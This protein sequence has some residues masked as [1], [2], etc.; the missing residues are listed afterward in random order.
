LWVAAWISGLLCTTDALTR[1][2]RDGTLGLLFLTDLQNYDIVLGKLA[3]T[4]LQQVMLLVGVLPI[5][6][7]ALA[8]GGVTA[9]EFW[10]TVASLLLCQGTSLALGLACSA[11]AKTFGGSLRATAFCLAVPILIPLGIFVILVNTTRTIPPEIFSLSPLLH[12][13]AGLD[14]FRNSF[15]AA[16]GSWE[17]G[18][19]VLLGVI[20]ASFGFACT[21]IRR[22]QDNPERYSGRA[23]ST[24]GQSSSLT[25][26]RHVHWQ[27]WLETN[28]Y[29]WLARTFRGDP[30]WVRPTLGGLLSVAG[31]CAALTWWEPLGRTRQE[32]LHIA[33]LLFVFVYHQLLKGAVCFQATQ[34]LGEDQRSGALELLLTT[35]LTPE[36]LIQGNRN[37]LHDDARPWVIAVSILTVFQLLP[38]FWVDAL[39]DITNTGFLLPTIGFGM[40]LL[41]LKWGVLIGLRAS[42][43][44]SDPARAF[45]SALLRLLFPGW[46]AAFALLLL[47]FGAGGGATFAGFYFCYLLC[48]GIALWLAGWQARRAR[49]DLQFGLRDLAAGLG[50]DTNERELAEDFRKAAMTWEDRWFNRR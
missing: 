35:P 11:L 45:R 29:Y 38:L 42:L 24:D 3:A 16:R 2:K 8:L 9:V 50:Y 17:A 47:L 39:K 25:G 13:L 34:R 26:W 43:R 4:A 49:I 40:L 46:L 27:D 14:T 37:A 28:P 30:G 7:I 23:S 22:Y 12:F 44:S 15:P 18:C 6:A 19:Y 41:D 36:E 21:V 5:L 32:V 31:C 10:R 1:E 33:G 20:S 48:Y